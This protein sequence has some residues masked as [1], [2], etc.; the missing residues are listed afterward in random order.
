MMEDDL[1]GTPG[2]Q[3]FEVGRDGTAIPAG[4]S[5]LTPA[6]DGEDVRLTVDPSLQWYAQNALAQQIRSSGAKSGYVVIMDARS[7]DLLSVASYP[8][9]NPNTDVGKAG[10]DLDNKAFSDVFEPGSTAKIMTMAAALEER[11][12]TPSTPVVIP[13]RLPRYDANFQ[14]AHDHPT[15]Y[16]TVAGTLAESSN[17]GTVLVSETLKPSTLEAY[18]RKF[19][20]GSTTGTGY[21]GESAGLLPASDTWSGTK[22]ATVAFG[23]GISVT[24]VQAASV[25]QTI[26][27]G[28]VRV[29]PRLVESVTRSDGS[30]DTMP[31]S[32]STRVVSEQTASDVGKMLEGVVG[33]NGTAEE[34]QIPGYRIAGKTG[35]ADYY[36]DRLGKYDGFTASFIGYAPADDPEIV[37]A[38]VVQKPRTSI[39]G[40][41]VAAPVFKDVMTYALQ[42][43]GIP[44]TGTKRPKLTIE[45]DPEE[46]LV[47]PHL[48]RNG[49]EQTRR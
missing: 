13:N 44:P 28:G 32:T 11:T 2:K 48:L 30:V 31:A 38:V 45:V 9:F 21:P 10:V 8:T 25:F 43:R 6:V 17:I 22:Q 19:G 23:Q 35:T 47:D 27:N 5:T 7:G 46:A 18:F 24:A 41:V 29:D 36:D 15:L 26:A 42:E 16:R 1:Q 39:Y 4:H 12:V 33:P 14:D 3:T 20:L 37:V 49:V 40:G 34:A